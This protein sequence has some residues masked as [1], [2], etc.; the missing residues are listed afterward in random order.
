L[1]RTVPPS[2]LRYGSGTGCGCGWGGGGG[3]GA[4]SGAGSGWRRP[5]R[6]RPERP[7][8]SDRISPIS[9]LSDSTRGPSGSAARRPRPIFGRGS[10]CVQ[11]RSD[12]LYVDRTVVHSSNAQ[13]RPAPKRDARSPPPGSLADNDPVGP[14]ISAASIAHSPSMAA[15]SAGAAL[16]ETFP[17]EPACKRITSGR[18]RVRADAWS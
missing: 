16:L 7:P 8:T 6:P 1:C 4:G 17:R 12:G 15:R 2:L 5:V 13:T 11:Q 14:N 9:S 3:A 10:V 18:T